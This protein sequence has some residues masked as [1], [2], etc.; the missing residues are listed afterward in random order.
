MYS[1]GR[2][3]YEKYSQELCEFPHKYSCMIR[4]KWPNQVMIYFSYYLFVF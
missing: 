2:K 3:P 4:K 1:I